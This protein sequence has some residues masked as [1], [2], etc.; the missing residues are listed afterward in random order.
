MIS[1][2]TLIT[3]VGT[4][5]AVNVAVVVLLLAGIGYFFKRRLSEFHQNFKEFNKN[6][7]DAAVAIA[8]LQ[9]TVKSHD[10]LITELRAE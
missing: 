3:I 9:V 7:H 2:E 4:I 1:L 6:L 5:A 10:S 8:K